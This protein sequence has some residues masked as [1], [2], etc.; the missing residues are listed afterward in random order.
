M[1]IGDLMKL[2]GN[3]ESPRQCKPSDFPA[4]GPSGSE[5]SS[6]GAGQLV[7]QT[8]EQESPGST[9]DNGD[10]TPSNWAKDTWKV[11]KSIGEQGTSVSFKGG[12]DL[13]CGSMVPNAKEQKY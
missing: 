6:S 1:A 8:A 13:C 9:Q 4:V 12:V 10:Q 2:N 5:G 7:K 11:G 3:L